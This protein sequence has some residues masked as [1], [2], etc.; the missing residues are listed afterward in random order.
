MS[1][2]QL[3]QD[4]RVLSRQVRP[5][6][7]HLIIGA[8]AAGIACMALVSAFV[9]GSRNAAPSEPSRVA[10]KHSS[11][12]PAGAK[13][14]PN[15]APREAAKGAAPATRAA[16]PAPAPAAQTEANATP[17]AS[18]SQSAATENQQATPSGCEQQTWPYVSHD[19]SA[20]TGKRRRQRHVRVI[21]TDRSA[22]P[23]VV[24]APPAASHERATDGSA[25]PS[26]TTPEAASAT[27]TSG[28]SDS[29]SIALRPEP[30]ADP[31]P[32]REG[33][34]GAPPS[35]VPM[36]RAK[37][38]ELARSTP[39][40]AIAARSADEPK[41][42]EASPSSSPREKRTI[43]RSEDQWRM[44]G[45]ARRDTPA[46][47]FTDEPQRGR[48]EARETSDDGL[49]VPRRAAPADDEDGETVVR[50]ERPREGRRSTSGYQRAVAEEER[51]HSRAQQPGFLL[52]FQFLFNP[53]GRGE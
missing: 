12:Q 42:E 28:T 45:S 11:D 24:T 44:R 29:A 43:R 21:A 22:P 19:C 18:A 49:R 9:P 6:S 34:A 3:P 15:G 46:R 17:A 37:P 26:A 40:P 31:S 38:E 5:R 10:Q 32:A 52:P 27:A 41:H 47:D 1:F 39:Q 25:A 53:P 2:E 13:S 51:P 50:S 30:P 23:T 16:E 33:A 14:K 35:D 4:I 8:F 20:Q 48:D 36:P 7:W